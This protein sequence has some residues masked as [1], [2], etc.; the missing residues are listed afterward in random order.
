MAK[1]LLI[2]RLEATKGGRGRRGSVC[3]TRGSESKVGDSGEVGGTLRILR[4]VNGLTGYHALISSIRLYRYGGKVSA[5]QKIGV[6]RNLECGGKKPKPK[7]DEN[8]VRVEVFREDR[9]IDPT[10]HLIDC[11]CTGQI[12]ETNRINALEG[13]PFKFD[14]SVGP[15]HHHRLL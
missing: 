13:L 2:V 7:R 4:A 9:N 14:R 12:C 6:A 8:F 15:W 10:H 1:Y 5:G 11:M 3:R